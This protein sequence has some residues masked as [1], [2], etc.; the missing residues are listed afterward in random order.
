M[1]SYFSV[2]DANKILPT[3]IKKFSYAK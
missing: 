3:V 2:D 1:N